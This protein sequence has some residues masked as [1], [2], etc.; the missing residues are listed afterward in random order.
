LNF[1]LP[2]TSE[3]YV[4]RIGRTA[5]A[6]AGGHAITFATPD[7][8]GEIRSI[9]RLIRKTLPV[10]KLPELPLLAVAAEPSHLPRPWQSLRIPGAQRRSG[11]R[12][13]P[14]FG[15]HSRGHHPGRERPR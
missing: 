14:R 5:R 7:Q 9:E 6:G 10:A 13:P 15:Y 12:H 3:D 2:S 11:R 8:Q 1:D 4:H